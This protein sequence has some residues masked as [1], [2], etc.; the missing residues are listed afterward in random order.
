[1]PAPLEEPR[2]AGT[3]TGLQRGDAW[4]Y[5]LHDTYAFMA[6]DHPSFITEITVLDVQVGMA[7]ATALHFEESL[8]M[9]QRPQCFFD[10]VHTMPL[11]N[12]SSF[13]AY[14]LVSVSELALQLDPYNQPS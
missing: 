7:D 8:A 5:L 12:N 3:I 6:K 9:S 2:H 1:M 13:H 14:L 10:H 11:G 4:P